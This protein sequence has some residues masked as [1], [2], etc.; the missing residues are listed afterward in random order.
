MIAGLVLSNSEK[1]ESHITF[2]GDETASF[3]LKENSDIMDKIEEFDPEILAVD[4]GTEQ[5][6]G[7]LT[8]QEEDLK[9]EG[10]SFTPT[11][12]EK[13]KSKRL[14]ALKASLTRQGVNP[15][16][17]RFDPHITAK[18]L[19]IDGDHALESMGV[20]TDEL[21]NSHQFDAMLGA[22]TAR[23]YQQDQFEDLGVIVPESLSDDSEE[24]RKP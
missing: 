12:M 20:E 1:E 11:S 24:D 18:E 3:S 23:F 17:I 8:S 21:N 9:E 19:A 5:M 6:R 15:E 7:E 2:L 22:V 14:Q 4:A 13:K 16:L 10:Y